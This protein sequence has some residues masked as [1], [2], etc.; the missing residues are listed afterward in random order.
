MAKFGWYSES[1]SELFGSSIWSTEVGGEVRVSEVTRE[2]T[3]ERF[4]ASVQ[5]V[6]RVVE[7]V[8][9]GTK[10]KLEFDCL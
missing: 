6:G 1:Q 9:A 2:Y 5:Y 10:G 4:K 8:R 3:P 7:F